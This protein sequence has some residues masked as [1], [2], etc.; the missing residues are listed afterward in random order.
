MLLLPLSQDVFSGD[1]DGVSPKRVRL[2]RKTSA[3]PRV[4]GEQSDQSA[5]AVHAG[6]GPSQRAE[7][8]THSQV[9]ARADSQVARRT[10]WHNFDARDFEDMQSEHKY[11]FVYNRFRQWLSELD[12]DS[13]AR[14]EGMSHFAPDRVRLAQDRFKNVS[15]SDKPLWLSAFATHTSAP[16]EVLAFIATQWRGRLKGKGKP[17][18][19]SST[20]FFTWQGDWGVVPLDDIPLDGTEEEV[21]AG[22]R[23]R[24]AVLQ[25]WKELCAFILQLQT[26]LCAAHVA[27]ALEVCSQTFLEEGKL[28]VHGHAFLKNDQSKFRVYDAKQFVFKA[29]S[30]HRTHHVWAKAVARAPWAGMYY[31]T[32]P[33]KYGLFTFTTAHPF[34]GF[35]VSPEWVFN[36]VESGKITY[37]NAREQLITCGKGLMRRLADLD[38]WHRNCEFLEQKRH[39]DAVQASIR[40]SFVAF[41]EVPQVSEW[42]ATVQRPS[43]SRKKFLVL[44][45][46][47]QTGKTEYA[48][49][50]FPIGSV[51]EL[52]CAGVEVVCLQAFNQREHKCIIWDEISPS[53]VSSNRKL[54]QHGA[55]WIDMGHSP[56][57]QHVVRVWLNDCCS[58]CVS[59]KWREELQRM[60]L[61]DATWLEA[62][63]IVCDVL[64]PLWDVGAASVA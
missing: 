57:G 52:N 7:A 50:L 58:I 47:S 4:A 60:P 8:G 53:L 55:C 16:E 18:L 10:P 35:P 27:C 64:S 30:P 5:A 62:N 54:F 51:L 36:L 34:R 63:S 37:S 29:S 59:N 6:P 46:R 25:L 22:L 42:L 15:A 17:W 1:A 21:V 56:T 13:F 61:V 31:L 20:A 38:C 41:P 44:T 23:S 3:T 12:A 45:G 11:H 24:P 40:D 19:D 26:K 33:K 28:R 39:A 14:I 48:R 49:S 32:A 43:L 9:V 2:T